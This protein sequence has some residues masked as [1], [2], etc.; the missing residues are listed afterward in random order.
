MKFCEGVSYGRV[1]L[2]RIWCGS[3]YVS[4]QFWPN[5]DNGAIDSGM[6]SVCLLHMLL[7]SLVVRSTGS[8]NRVIACV[9]VGALHAACRRGGG[10][11]AR[12]MPHAVTPPQMLHSNCRA[13]SQ[14]LWPDATRCGH[15]GIGLRVYSLRLRLRHRS[16]TQ[17]SPSIW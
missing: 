17:Q 2:I 10:R 15:R 8:S 9:V 5:G 7:I 16:P 4:G 6:D 13:V 1:R 3:G 14:C 11:I 12:G